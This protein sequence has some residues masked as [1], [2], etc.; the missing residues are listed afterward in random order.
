MQAAENIGGSIDVWISAVDEALCASL[1]LLLATS[2]IHSAPVTSVSDLFAPA[3]GQKVLIIDFQ[4][5]KQ[6]NSALEETSPGKGW[7]GVVIV[8]MED[9]R[10]PLPLLASGSGK[11]LFVTKPFVSGEILALLNGSSADVANGCYEDDA[12]AVEQHGK[13]VQDCSRGE[14]VL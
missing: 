2:G 10:A 12:I 14:A 6:V 9:K 8:M 11:Y 4:L 5:L 3:A 13:G 7:E 1:V